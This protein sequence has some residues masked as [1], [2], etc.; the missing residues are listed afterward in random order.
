MDKHQEKLEDAKKEVIDML[1]DI[2]ENYSTYSHIAMLSR[3]NTISE[4]VDKHYKETYI[5]YLIVKSLNKDL[6]EYY[7]RGKI[8]N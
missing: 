7:H 5:E 2:I 4:Y 6:S 3:L 8:W 1:E